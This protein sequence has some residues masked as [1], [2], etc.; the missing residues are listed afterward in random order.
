MVYAGRRGVRSYS[1]PVVGAPARLGPPRGR[2]VVP[3]RGKGRAVE[4]I[5]LTLYGLSGKEQASYD[6]KLGGRLDVE[7]RPVFTVTRIV[8][9]PIETQEAMDV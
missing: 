5:R 4:V 1:L 3:A 8:L 7:H 9:E 2:L 6:L